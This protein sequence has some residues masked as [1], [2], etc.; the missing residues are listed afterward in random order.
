[1]HGQVGRAAQ[2]ISH[3]GFNPVHG[4]NLTR[5]QR[6]R[7]CGGVIDD[8]HFDAVEI[9]EIRVPVVGEFGERV[10]HAR[11]VNLKL[12]RAGADARTG[13]VHA[14]I[15]LND[16]VIIGHQIGQVGVRLGQCDLEIVAIGLH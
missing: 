7:P 2:Q 14:A 15:G 11:L 9:A 4:V 8:N 13:I 10:A 6:S 1:M 16:Q 12:V 5:L 3:F